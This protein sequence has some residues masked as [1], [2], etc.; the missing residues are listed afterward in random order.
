MHDNLIL[1]CFDSPNKTNPSSSNKTNKHSISGWNTYV[2]SYYKQALFWHKLWKDNGSP[3]TGYIANIR[4]RTRSQY[5]YAVRYVK[6]NS[7]TIL[8]SKM[9]EC[10]FDNNPSEFWQKFSKIKCNKTVMPSCI[11]NVNNGSHI[12]DLFLEKYKKLYNCVPY[13]TETLRRLKKQMENNVLKSCAAATCYSTHSVNMSEV[14]NAVKLLNNGKSDGRLGQMI[15]HLI[16]GSFWF[17]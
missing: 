11:E 12:S 14:I 17:V 15:Y 6:T 2:D 4:N 10:L 8:A 7:D 9:A 13:C 1:A 3:R 5:H 16:H